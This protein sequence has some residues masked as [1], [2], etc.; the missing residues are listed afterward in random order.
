M[1]KPGAVVETRPS[2]QYRPIDSMTTSD[3]RTVAAPASYPATGFGRRQVESALL[4][5]KVR[6]LEKA[7]P[8]I[9]D[10]DHLKLL[11][12]A[13]VEAEALAWLTPFPILFLPALLEEKFEVARRYVARQ[14]AVRS[15]AP[16]F[17]D[18]SS[19]SAA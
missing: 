6:L 18:G 13:A 11:H 5:L 16:G 19:G 2:L 9:G 7:L 12:L 10:P 17:I 3:E 4:D 15:V 8:T 14:H 1:M